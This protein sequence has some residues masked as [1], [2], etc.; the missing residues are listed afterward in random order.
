MQVIAYSGLYGVGWEGWGGG[1]GGGGGG[2]VR[3][4]NRHP[5]GYATGTGAKLVRSIF[6]KGCASELKA[7]G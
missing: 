7:Q 5:P 2:G 1:G 4:T 3:A 6:A